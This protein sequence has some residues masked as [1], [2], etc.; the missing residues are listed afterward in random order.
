MSDNSKKAKSFVRNQK[1][2]YGV[3]PKVRNNVFKNLEGTKEN[4]YL[5]KK[6]SKKR[7]NWRSNFKPH[8]GLESFRCSIDQFSEITLKI[9]EIATAINVEVSDSLIR[10]I[11]G[12]VALFIHLRN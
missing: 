4:W 1:A 2:N 7:E 8:V 6:D 10:K 3:R 11:E 5:R 9:K 12:I